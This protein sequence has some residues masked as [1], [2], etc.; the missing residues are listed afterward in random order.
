MQKLPRT[1][2]TDSLHYW[3]SLL[4]SECSPSLAQLLSID[5]MHQL[6]FLY[7]LN[8][9]ASHLLAVSREK[10]QNRVYL[11]KIENSSYHQELV[12]PPMPEHVDELSSLVAMKL[13]QTDINH[14]G[15]MWISRFLSFT[16]RIHSCISVLTTIS[17][18]SRR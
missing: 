15:R 12:S 14:A 11:S 16:L 17:K 5:Y 2:Q 7:M 9:V 4:F 10:G 13:Q 18:K 6:S 3:H 1:C 8:I